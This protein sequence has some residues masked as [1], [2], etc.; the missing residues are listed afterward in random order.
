MPALLRAERIAAICALPGRRLRRHEGAAGAGRP[1]P[2]VP[3]AGGAAARLRPRRRRS[4]S[5]R[6]RG[7]SR[8]SS[9]PS[10]TVH[11]VL[12]DV[13]GM[14]VLLL[15]DSGIGKSECA[16]DL[17]QRGHRLVA[18]DVVEIRKYPNGSLVGRAAEMIRYHMELRGIGII[19]IKHLFGVSAVRASK[20]I[21]LVI[22]LERW[23]PTKRTTGSGST[24]RPTRSSSGRGRFCRLPVASGRNIALL[25]EIAARN[26][27]LKTQGYDAAKEFALKV[28][29]QIAQE[30]ARLAATQLSRRGRS[31][32][33]PSASSPGK[34]RHRDGALRIG[35]ELRQQV[36]RGHRLLLRR[37]PAARARR[38]AA[39]PGDRALASASSWTSAIREFAHSF[40]EILARLRQSVPGTR[41][42]FLDASEESLIRRFS[43]TRRPHPLSE[44]KSLLQSL[45][46]ER[47]MLQE[48]RSVA[49][50]VVDTSE[51]TVH[52]LR[53]FIQKNFAANADEARM[54]VSA[55]SFGYKFGVP[56]DVDLLFD[57]RFLANPHFVPEL[58]GKTGIGP[59]RR[60]VHRKGRGHGSVP[61]E[62]DPVRRL[63]VAALRAGAQEL[64]LDRN[65]LHRREAPLG[66][67][68]GATLRASQRTRLSGSRLA[69]RRDP[70]VTR[71]V[72]R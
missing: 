31:A 18:D 1:R 12:V 70:S 13:Y 7:C 61:G 41:L 30:H 72:R 6:S 24:A 40:P 5:S 14:G 59:R 19:N 35:Q 37:Q 3:Q 69:P 10:T 65:R 26:E 38:A 54:V 4:S 51:M 9:H 36:S 50:V 23:D 49:D 64:S 55:T 63:P 16:L 57:V 43:E 22:E 33:G 25:I 68:R 42:L 47:Q 39:L 52:E 48:V 8:T 58:K 21:E 62:A 29:E 17:I 44:N 28:D 66:L 71:P 60:R 53:S 45:R 32:R 46:S 67:H 11:G 34:P 27:L 15:G 20:S 2:R 56:H